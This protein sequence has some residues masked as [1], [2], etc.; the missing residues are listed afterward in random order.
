MITDRWYKGYLLFPV[1]DDQGVVEYWDIHEN[2]GEHSADCD[3]IAWGLPTLA[4]AKAWV[5]ADVRFRRTKKQVM[6]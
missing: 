6:R 5:T 1:L 3:P 2:N 4:A